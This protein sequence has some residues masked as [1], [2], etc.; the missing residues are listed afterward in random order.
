M[1]NDDINNRKF[2]GEMLHANSKAPGDSPGGS[3]IGKD[4]PITPKY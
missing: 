4:V 3:I 1:C 2:T